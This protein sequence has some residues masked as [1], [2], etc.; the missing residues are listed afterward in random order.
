MQRKTLYFTAPH[1]VEL[2]EE[3]LPALGADEVLVETVC[4]AISAGTE[5]LVYRGQFPK[6][7]DAI[8]S[9]S[10]GL[11]YPLPY[12]YASV[13]RVKQIGKSVKR[14]WE[15]Q[16]AFAFQPHASH[17]VTTP[18]SLF[19]IPDSLP[20]E[21]AC[22][23]PNME[24]AVNLV[25]DAAPILGERVLVLGQGIVGLLTTALLMEFPLQTLVTADFYPLRRET[26]MALGVTASL[27]SSTVDFSE[28]ALSHCRSMLLPHREE[29]DLTKRGGF[30][31]VFE[32]SGNPTALN[33]AL[34]VTAFSG[35]V[36]IGSWYGE[37]RAPIDLGSTFHRSRI[38]LI[39]SQVS[40]IAPELSARWDK[41]RRF[42]VAWEALKRIQTEKWI[43]HRY[44]LEKARDAYQLLDQNPQDAIQ[45]IFNHQT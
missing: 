25:Q 6:E 30:D 22:F 20:P 4:S 24:T 21:A 41:S 5:M 23:L 19:P 7:V 10:S 26:S 27:D 3:T 29:K 43:T 37:K 8:D 44:P 33:H 28:K 45:V 42:Q 36:V 39:S 31:L 9:I 11:R 12:G 38:K 14:E 2:R 32:V 16:L 13:G 1:Q 35:R 34:E 18:E 15:N 40:T 17:F